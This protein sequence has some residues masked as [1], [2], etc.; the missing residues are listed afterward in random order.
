[1]G[2][3][4]HA[5][6]VR[7][8]EAELFEPETELEARLL[9]RQPADLVAEDALRQLARILRGGDGDDR[10]GMHVIDIG[11]VHIGMERRVDGGGAR[12]EI[13]G[14]VGEIAH[15]LVFEIDAAIEA[16]QGPELVHVEG[17]KAIELDRGIVA[18][19]TLDPEDL[20]H[21]AGQGVLLHDL[22][23]GIAAAVIGDALV[24]PEEVGAI[25]QPFGLAHR[26][27]LGV[28]PQIGEAL[29]R[30][31]HDLP[32]EKTRFTLKRRVGRNWP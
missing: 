9:P 22:G 21:F 2:F 26:G 28:V 31:G 16:L 32:P 1:M 30:G 17:G 19:R 10:I 12:V 24:G 13:E 4:D 20:D 5:L 14:G 18:A 11:P 15:H 25:D 7:I 6:G 8:V 3:E 23:R 27:C 29:G